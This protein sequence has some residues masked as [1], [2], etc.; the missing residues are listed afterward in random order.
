MKDRAKTKLEALRAQ[1]ELDSVDRPVPPA[2]CLPGETVEPA[3]AVPQETIRLHGR[4]LLAEDSPDH[5]WLLSYVLKRAGAEVVTAGDGRVAYEQAMQA[6]AAGSPFD[7]ILMDM[8]MPEVDGHEATVRLRKAGYTGPIIAL[9]AY[10]MRGDREKCLAAGCSDY[11]AKPISPAELL[12][13]VSRH[14]RP[15][16]L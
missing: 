1:A 3:G 2:E 14:L 4:I 5:Q 16:A 6:C 11:A 7:L 12:G 13:I 10:A 9:T 8:Q 15:A